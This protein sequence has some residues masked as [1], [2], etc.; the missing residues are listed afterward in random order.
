MNQADIELILEV[1]LVLIG[2]YLAFFKSYFQE[3]GK[4]L[5]TSEDIAKI[6]RKVETVKKELEEEFAKSKAKIDLLYNL[7]LNEIS[8][9]INAIVNFHKVFSKWMHSLTSSINLIDDKDNEEIKRK[10][11]DYDLLYDEVTNENSILEIY[12][13]N[14]EYSTLIDSLKINVLKELSGKSQTALRKLELNNNLVDNANTL[15]DVNRKYEELHKLREERVKIHSDFNSER[16]EGL[17]K[18]VKEYHNYIN[19]TR[20]LVRMKNKNYG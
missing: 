11:F 8:N 3:K 19:E 13:D 1:I 7:E 18:V 2:L 12:C 9:E 16:I 4:N 17:K 20:K 15:V 14:H 6:T 5:A 10:I